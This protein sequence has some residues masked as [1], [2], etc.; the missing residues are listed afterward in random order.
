MVMVQ[1]GWAIWEGFPALI[2]VRNRP[3]V[4]YHI[5]CH[6]H[7]YVRNNTSAQ[8]LHRSFEGIEIHIATQQQQHQYQ[9]YSWLLMEKVPGPGKQVEVTVL[10]L[11][12]F[13]AF[14]EGK[15]RDHLGGKVL[16]NLRSSTPKFDGNSSNRGKVELDNNYGGRSE[17]SRHFER[18]ALSL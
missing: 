12:H 11:P 2:I 14:F 7:Y 17:S 6:G 16:A 18:L 10:T 13:T 8:L 5:G 15:V 9:F 1:R 4:T 3:P